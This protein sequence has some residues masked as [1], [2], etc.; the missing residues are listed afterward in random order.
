MV[1]LDADNRIVRRHFTLLTG[2]GQPVPSPTSDGSIDPS[3]LFELTAAQPAVTSTDETT[4]IPRLVHDA[5]F[6]GPAG[7]HFMFWDSLNQAG[8][9]IASIAPRTTAAQGKALAAVR[10]DELLVVLAAVNPDG[11]LVVLSGDPQI[12]HSSTSGAFQI[13]PFGLYRRVAGPAIAS[14]G[15]GLVDIVAIEDGGALNWFTGS[16]PAAGSGFSGPVTEPSAVQF[17]PGA[18]PALMSTGSLLLAAAVGTDGSL[19]VAT[20][21]PVLLTMDVPVEVDVTVSIARS[22]PVALGRTAFS[23]VVVAVDSQNTVRAA[24]RPISGGSW[25][26]LIPLL[27]PLAISPLGGVSVVSI[28]LG[29]MAIAISVDGIVCSALSVDGLIWSPLIPL[30]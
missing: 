17:D 20:I 27:A 9:V 5:F 1:H 18:R 25:T 12:L 4:P 10:A 11:R 21:D 23:A 7:I 15:A 22:G 29:V 16:L 28:D 19:R 14:R 13:D 2:W 26:P 24:T 30:P 8:N 6:S 3:D